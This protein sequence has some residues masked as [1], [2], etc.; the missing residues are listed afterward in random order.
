MSAHDT[1]RAILDALERAGHLYNPPLDGE[2]DHDT[3]VA[4]VAGVL[5]AQAPLPWWPTVDEWL[6][7]PPAPSSLDAL[8]DHLERDGEGT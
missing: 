3:L 8:L 6:A 4:L 7:G 5:E 1:A 2:P